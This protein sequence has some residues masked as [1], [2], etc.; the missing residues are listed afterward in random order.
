MRSTQLALLTPPA[1]L[2]SLRGG[3]R[4]VFVF[5][6]VFVLVLVLVL[7]FVSTYAKHVAAA[8]PRRCWRSQR[9]YA[10]GM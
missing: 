3:C 8:K 2:S 10:E 6:F 5:V 4:F 1:P 9:N 7:V